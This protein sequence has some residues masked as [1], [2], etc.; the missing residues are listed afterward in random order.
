MQQ[1]ELVVDL[2]GIC[3]RREENVILSNFSLQLESGDFVYITGPVGAGKS[4]LLKALYAEMPLQE[5]EAR[6]VGFDLRRVKRSQLCRMRRK[7]GIVFQDFQLLYDLTAE[8]NL[9]IVLRAIRVKSKEDRR[10]RID[11][12]LEQVGMS[13]KGYKRPHEL[14]GG[15]QQRIAIARA[16][17]GHPELILADEPTGNLDT[18][19]GLEITRLLHRMAAQEGAAVVMATHNRL[20]MEQLPARHVC[21]G[22]QEDFT[23]PKATVLSE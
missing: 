2:R 19:T 16:L 17:L 22:K 15:E 8:E 4:S 12:V 3:I 23:S 21:L 13:N 10:K 14:S 7:I 9:D 11:E 18:A 5:G 20:V 6:I 1:K